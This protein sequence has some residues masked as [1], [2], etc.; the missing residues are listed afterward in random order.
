VP[1]AWPTEAVAGGFGEIQ[2][3]YSA[4]S[5][6]RDV[7]YNQQGRK[8]LRHLVVLIITNKPM[9]QGLPFQ[10]TAQSVCLCLW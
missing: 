9:N 1:S 8:P 2:T 4:R 5:G 7:G 6:E 3:I 10:L